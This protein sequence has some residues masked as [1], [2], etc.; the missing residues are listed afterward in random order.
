VYKNI[1]IQKYEVYERY[2]L[3]NEAMN[4]INGL[5]LLANCQEKDK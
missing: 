4:I 1:N 5:F 2:K 3:E